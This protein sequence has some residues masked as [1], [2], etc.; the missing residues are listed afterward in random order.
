V[1]DWLLCDHRPR[2]AIDAWVGA[3]LGVVLTRDAYRRRRGSLPAHSVHV[4]LRKSLSRPW[5][6]QV[7]AAYPRLP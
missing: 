2:L 7:A 3:F 4:V 1:D 6:F 5:G